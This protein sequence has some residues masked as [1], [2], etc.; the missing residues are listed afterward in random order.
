MIAQH[1]GNIVD[2][3]EDDYADG[4]SVFYTTSLSDT[5]GIDF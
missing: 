1:G 4:I 5:L 3:E 2:M